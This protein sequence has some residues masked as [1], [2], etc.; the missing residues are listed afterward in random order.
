M[1]DPRFDWDEAKA[2]ENVRKHGVSLDE[3][4]EVFDDPLSL[5]VRDPDHSDSE[6]RMIIIGESRQRRILVVGYVHR[7]DRFRLFNARRA[8][9]KEKRQYMNKDHD[10]LRDEYDFS[11]GVRGRYYNPNVAFAV[12]IEKDVAEFFTTG[13]EVN[14]GLRILIREGRVPQASRHD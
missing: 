11:Q 14:E 10:E 4:S 1:E 12:R 7:G 8:K 13:Y 6:E 9:P 2:V 3:G 5:S